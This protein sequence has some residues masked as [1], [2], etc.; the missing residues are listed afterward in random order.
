MGKLLLEGTSARLGLALTGYEN[1][2]PAGEE[3]ET[4]PLVGKHQRIA[5]RGA[6]EARRSDPHTSG[7][8]SDRSHQYHRVKP[9]FGK[10]RVA[11]PYRIPA[12]RLGIRRQLQHLR[13][14]GRADDDAAIGKSEPEFHPASSHLFS[15]SP[16]WRLRLRYYGSALRPSNVRDAP[17]LSL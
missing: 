12:K 10:N 1:G 14:G 7:A 13:H 3:I 9:G 11:D 6:G 8:G 17:E 2:A 16:C 5:Q 15:P 4:S